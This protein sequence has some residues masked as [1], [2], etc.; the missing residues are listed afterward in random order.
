MNPSIP[1]R[2]TLIPYRQR[3]KQLW[4]GNFP[5]LK[6]EGRGGGYVEVSCC[7]FALVSSARVLFTHCDDSF[8]IGLDGFCFCEGC[9]D[10]FVDD[11]GGDEVAED[12][13][14]LAG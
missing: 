4:H 14:A 9:G 6:S 2:S 7:T 11:E 12:G 5:I 8:C 3:I 10:G 13:F 1:P